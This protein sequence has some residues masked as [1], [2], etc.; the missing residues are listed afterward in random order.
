[1][2]RRGLTALGLASAVALMACGLDPTEEA[3]PRQPKAAASGAGG[4]NSFSGDVQPLFMEFCSACHNAQ[5]LTG[6]IDLTSYATIQSVQGLV[7]AGNPTGS[8]LLQMLEGGM[9][10]PAGRPRPSAKEITTIHT[11]VAEGALNN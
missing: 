1:M 5:L 6:G 2:R 7:V 9:M 8:I 10:P 4:G 3:A 11:W